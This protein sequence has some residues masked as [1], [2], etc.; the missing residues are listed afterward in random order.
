VEEANVG[1]TSELSAIL[2]GALRVNA[3]DI[4]PQLLLLAKL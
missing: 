4:K 3:Y 1:I 2:N